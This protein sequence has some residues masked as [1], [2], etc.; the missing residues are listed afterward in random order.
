M[1]EDVALCGR[2]LRVH[3]FAQGIP[4]L[5][6]LPFGFDERIEGRALTFIAVYLRS[7]LVYTFNGWGG[8]G[9]R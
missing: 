8:F 2:G 5:G 1:G 6:T 4:A 3:P 7:V 9:H